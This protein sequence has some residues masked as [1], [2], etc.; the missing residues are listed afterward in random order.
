M[1]AVVGRR[2]GVILVDVADATCV[3][4]TGTALVG[5]ADSCCWKDQLGLVERN[6]GPS[7]SLV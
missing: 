1:V 5:V 4:V 2:A 7:P 6:L 3:G